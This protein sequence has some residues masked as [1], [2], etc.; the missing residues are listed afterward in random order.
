MGKL[1]KTSDVE[2]IKK[3]KA[4][5][6]QQVG[7]QDDFLVFLNNSKCAMNFSADE[8]KKMIMTDMLYF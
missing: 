5:G 7:K 4:A 6:F 1:I 3:L 8:K 2:I